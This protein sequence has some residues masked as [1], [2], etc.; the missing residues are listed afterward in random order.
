MPYLCTAPSQITDQVQPFASGTFTVNVAKLLAIV[1]ERLCAWIC[2]E[3]S[4]A[5]AV[6]IGEKRSKNVVSTKKQVPFFRAMRLAL[7]N[8]L[9]LN[10]ALITYDCNFQLNTWKIL[11]LT[12]ITFVSRE[13]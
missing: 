2:G 4:V 3:R 12:L 13:K 6:G 11:L 9:F 10:G 5:V 7:C 8:S 1:A